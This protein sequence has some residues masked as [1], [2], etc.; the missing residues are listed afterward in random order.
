M[1][2][3]S[4]LDENFEIFKTDIIKHK[5]E[6]VWIIILNNACDEFEKSN[7]KFEDRR[8][9]IT[10]I[11]QNEKIVVKFKDNAN[12]GIDNHILPKIFEPFASTKIDEGMG[13]GLNIAKTIIEQHNATIKAYNED[14]CA[15]FEIKI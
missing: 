2:V 14:S 12:K 9:D 3:R 6:Q 5:I 8:I 10:I 1:G 4:D 15:V 13:V 11:Q 7:K